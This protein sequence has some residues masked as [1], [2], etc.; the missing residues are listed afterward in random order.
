MIAPESFH[1]IRKTSIRYVSQVRGRVTR[2]PLADASPF[3]HGHRLP[4]LAQQ[5]RRR[6]P[7]DP[8]A[9]NQGV[10]LQIVSSL[11]NAGCWGAVDPERTCIHTAVSRL[12]R[13]SDAV[14]VFHVRALYRRRS[15][16]AM[17]M[18]AHAAPTR[19]VS[20]AEVP[21]TRS[22]STLRTPRRNCEACPLYRNATQTVFGE[23]AA[24]ARIVFIGEQPGDE[25]DRK[26]R[27]FVGPAGTIARSRS[28]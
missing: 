2:F 24:K 3:D 7:R 28:G 21:Q 20:A 12:L 9:D 26:G 8:S 17:K 18:S 10:H 4:T 14:F 16:S 19:E 25:E 27:P 22:L 6:Q 15:T 1:Q 23:G 5:I 11:G 13:K